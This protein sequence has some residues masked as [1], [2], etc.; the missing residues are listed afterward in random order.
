LPA[1]AQLAE[2]EAVALFVDRA[3]AVKPGFTIGSENAPAI[4]AI[5]NR[6]D[7]LPLA[8][9]LAAARVRVLPPQRLLAELGRRLH[10]LTGGARDMPSRQ[11]TLRSAIDWSHELLTG[12]EQQLFRRLA[13]F[14]GGGALEAIEAVCNG[15]DDLPILA[16]LESLVGKSL[17][18]PT[19][20]DGDP[21]FTM[22]ETI[23]EY[24]WERLVDAGESERL[25]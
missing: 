2:N 16:T 14:V 10:L 22:L 9:E 8:I 15:E 19:E 24:A 25:R 3:M 12:A 17:V 7:G 6:L 23:R 4:A 18:R 20:A 13:V 1:L 11:K 21:R 5:C